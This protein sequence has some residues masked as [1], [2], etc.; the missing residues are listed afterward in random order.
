MNDLAGGSSG[1]G[2]PFFLPPVLAGAQLRGRT[3]ESE[4]QGGGSWRWIYRNTGSFAL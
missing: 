1:M 4:F 2:R 3:G